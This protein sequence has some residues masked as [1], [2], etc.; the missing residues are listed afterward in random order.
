MKNSS[1]PGVPDICMN[2]PPFVVPTPIR[3]AV[4]AGYQRGSDLQIIL[5]FSL[6]GSYCRSPYWI[7]ASPDFRPPGSPANLTRTAE[8][9][10]EIFD[11]LLLRIAL[12]AAL[13]T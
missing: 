2:Q 9:E 4:A 12:K 3:S 13:A 10:V 5:I 11:F 8:F 6:P 1:A 7:L